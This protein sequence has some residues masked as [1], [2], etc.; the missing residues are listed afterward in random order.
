MTLS[1]PD[2]VVVP[3]I[4]FDNQENTQMEMPTVEGQSEESEE[5]QM[6]VTGIAYMTI[7]RQWP[8]IAESLRTES[9]ITKTLQTIRNAAEVLRLAKEFGVVALPAYAY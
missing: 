9:D 4:S 2:R 3:L 8:A 7:Q 5:L 6:A 1:N